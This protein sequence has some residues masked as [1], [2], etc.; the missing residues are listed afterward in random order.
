M[1]IWYYRLGG[2]GHVYKGFGV[3]Q[4]GFRQFITLWFRVKALV[5]E[6]EMCGVL[7]NLFGRS[8]GVKEPSLKLTSGDV[9]LVYGRWF[10]E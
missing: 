7:C 1:Q 4:V 9:G 3:V 10:E 6:L 8:F 5:Y 2:Q